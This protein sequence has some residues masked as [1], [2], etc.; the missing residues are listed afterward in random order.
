M[1]SGLEPMSHYLTVNEISLVF[2]Q[3][4]LGS[5]HVPLR[6]EIDRVG[7]RQHKWL[8]VVG[9]ETIVISKNGLDGN[10]AY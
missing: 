2:Q 7:V 3:R 6:W 5:S 9:I 4:L 1:P 10:P 8:P